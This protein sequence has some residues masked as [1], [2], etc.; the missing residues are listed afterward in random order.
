MWDEQYHALVGKNLGNHWFKPTLYE[1][2]P[3]P[4]DYRN[5][6]ANHVWVHKQPLYLWQIALSMKIF[7]EREIA[8][9][10]P[11]VIMAACMVMMIFRSGSLLKSERTGMI[12]ALF[13]AFNYFTWNLVSGYFHTDHNDV[14]FA[15]YVTASVWSYLEYR[16]SGKFFFALLT[17]LFSGCAVLTKWLTGLLIF[18]GWGLGIVLHSERR[19]RFKEYRNMAI[20]LGVC[21]LTFLP[22][23]LYIL[24]AFPVESRH[25]YAE[26]TKHFSQVME[27][28]DGDASYHLDRLQ[29]ILFNTS[30]IFYI[31]LIALIVFAFSNTENKTE[32]WSVIAMIFAVFVFFTMAETK[33]PSFTYCVAP[34]LLI[35]VAA[36][37][38]DL[39]G[40]SRFAPE[41][42]RLW[43]NLGLT[44][45]FIIWFAERDIRSNKLREEHGNIP[46]N[47]YREIRTKHAAIYRGMQ[48]DSSTVIFNVPQFETTMVMFYTEATAYEFLPDSATVQQLQMKGYTVEV[49]EK[50]TLPLFLSTNTRVIKTKN[51]VW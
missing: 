37:I 31:V 19:K 32:R 36:L 48:R 40:L 5:W 45:F 3:L 7:G 17:G 8:L 6:T 22:W 26:A 46:E 39:I 4:Y 23:Q 15:F 34:L 44:G 2:T 28:H 25:E 20:A 33:M 30:F 12:A 24:K 35:L 1:H 11:S 10:L 9:R 50:D 47:S 41:K 13:F 27:G 18:G 51:G 29:D 16:K 21:V 49:F 42:F 14:A 43:F 38:D